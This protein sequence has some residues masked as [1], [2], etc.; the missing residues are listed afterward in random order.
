MTTNTIRATL[1]AIARLEAMDV[2][3]A[4]LTQPDLDKWNRL[5]RKLGWRDFIELLHLD[6]AAAFPV[7]FDLDRWPEPP[8]LDETTAEALIREAATP[9]DRAP[10]EFLRE[11]ARALGL[12]SGGALGEVPKV[13]PHHTALE[14]PGSGGRIAAYQCLHDSTLSFDRQFTLVVASPAERV[15]VG[16]AAVELR[17]NEPTLW[18]IAELEAAV[19]NGKSFDRVFGLTTSA[20]AR[21]LVERLDLGEVRLV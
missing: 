10:L 17:A 18:S 6:L 5:R 12:A 3:P 15:A 16:L 4:R 14:L 8:E 1:A 21:A 19:G 9:S 7:P 11:H 13:Q 2:R 20:D